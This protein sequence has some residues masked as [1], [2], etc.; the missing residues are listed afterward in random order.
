MLDVMT[1]SERSSADI[2]EEDEYFCGKVIETT[3]EPTLGKRQVWFT[4]SITMT[5]EPSGVVTLPPYSE[6]C[7]DGNPSL[8]AFDGI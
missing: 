2:S 7:A 8:S 6:N 5:V 4:Y 1:I 3:G